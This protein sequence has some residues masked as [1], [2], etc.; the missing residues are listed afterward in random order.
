MHKQ[1]NSEYRGK[2]QLKKSVKEKQSLT[3]SCAWA[4][5]KKKKY[6]NMLIMHVFD[7]TCQSVLARHETQTQRDSWLLSWVKFELFICCQC[8]D[9]QTC[10][11]TGTHC[12]FF[13]SYT[14]KAIHTDNNKAVLPCVSLIMCSP[15]L[16]CSTSFLLI[17]VKIFITRMLRNLNEHT[18][19]VVSSMVLCGC[20][21]N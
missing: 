5:S 11:R 4:G 9:I 18:F 3:A 14:T 2:A 15:P 13:T 19:T 7:M 8:A 6:I 10:A 1:L 16:S 12:F 21:W 17:Q 20:V